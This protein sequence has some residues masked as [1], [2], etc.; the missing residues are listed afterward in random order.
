MAEDRKLMSAD[1]MSVCVW[2]QR[3]MAEHQRQNGGNLP[4][5]VFNEDIKR[6]P[7][8]SP[9]IVVYRWMN[10]ALQFRLAMRNIEEN[11]ADVFNG[12]WH[13]TGGLMTFREYHI[14]GIRRVIR[15]ELGAAPVRTIELV[16][17][18]VPLLSPR[19]SDI[20]CQ[21]F[22]TQVE[23]DPIGKE[24]HGWFGVDG[25]MALKPMQKGGIVPSHLVGIALVAKHVGRVNPASPWFEHKSPHYKVECE[26][27]TQDILVVGE[28]TADDINP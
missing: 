17:T 13:Y 4:L 22:A 21:L 12:Q 6:S 9:E 25:A 16:G 3:R 1:D 10:G 15:K 28:I 14:G 5:D 7:R 20:N 19:G 2:A 11:S 8:V 23:G 26:G 24:G 27:F 18:I